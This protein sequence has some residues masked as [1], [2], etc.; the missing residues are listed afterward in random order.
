MQN[1]FCL[2]DKVRITISGEQEFKGEMLYSQ[3]SVREFIKRLKEV[4]SKNTYIG[5]MAWEEMCRDIDKLAGS[6][7]T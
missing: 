1:N 7:L 6:K 3:E 4:T 5:D 2:S